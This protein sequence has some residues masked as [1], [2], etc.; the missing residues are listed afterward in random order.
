MSK[1]MSKKLFSGSLGV[2]E[3]NQ[4][5]VSAKGI[6]EKR[7]YPSFRESYEHIRSRNFPRRGNSSRCL[8]QTENCC[9][10]FENEEEKRM[11]KL[12]SNLWS[13]ALLFHLES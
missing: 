13:P 1:G 12:N 7:N 6:E 2:E 9:F 10:C 5:V 11:R 3:L 4:L 8:V